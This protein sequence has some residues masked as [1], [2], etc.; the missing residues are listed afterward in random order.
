MDTT[1]LIQDLERKLDFYEYPSPDGP[2]L[3]MPLHGYIAE[4]LAAGTVYPR[5]LN[6][7]TVLGLLEGQATWLHDEEGWQALRDPV[8]LAELEE[9]RVVTFKCGL[10][11]VVRPVPVADDMPQK[12]KQQLATVAS[13]YNIRHG[14]DGWVASHVR[15]DEGRVTDV[16]YLQACDKLSASLGGYEVSFEDEDL[17][18]VGTLLWEQLRASRETPEVAFEEW[19]LK[20]VLA[21][22]RSYVFHLKFRSSEAREDFLAGAF[23]YVM[24]DDSLQDSWEQCAAD[25]ALAANRMN[26]IVRPARRD[27]AE[28]LTGSEQEAYCPALDLSQLG[29]VIERFRRLRSARFF[30]CFQW[31]KGAGNYYDYETTHHLVA[32]I[33]KYECEDGVR[34]DSFPYTRRLLQHSTQAPHLAEIL[35]RKIH[36]SPYLCLLLSDR[37]TSH[38]GLIKVHQ[39]LNGASQRLSDRYDYDRA[40]QQLVFAQALEVYAI[41]HDEPIDAEAA[42]DT[43]LAIAEVFAWLA[44]RETAPHAEG[45]G[46]VLLQGLKQ[47]VERMEYHRPEGG[48][49]LPLFKDH[50][51]SAADFLVARHKQLNDRHDEL[52]LAQWM[53]SFWCIEALSAGFMGRGAPETATAG[54]VATLLVNDYLWL[55]QQRFTSVHVDIDDGPVF[56]SFDWS[57]LLRLCNKPLRRKLIHAFDDLVVDEPEGSEAGRRGFFGAVRTH[58]RLLLALVVDAES[59]FKKDVVEALLAL[60][61]EF[62]FANDRLGGV[63]EVLKD[64]AGHGKVQ[65]WARVC[66]ASNMFAEDDFT[67]FL[68]ILRERPTPIGGLLELFEATLS[69]ARKARILEHVITLDLEAERI[70]WIPEIFRVTMMAANAGQLSLARHLAKYGASVRRSHSSVSFEPLA[71]LIELKA[72][73]EDA[74]LND[75]QR[76][77]ELEL[78]LDAATQVGD[79]AHQYARQLIAN[80][81]LTVDVQRAFHLFDALLKERKQLT[82]ATGRLKASRI[83]GKKKKTGVDIDPWQLYG[84]WH[85]VYRAV[86]LKQVDARDFEEAL[87][88]L[89][90][91][92]RWEELDR[93]WRELPDRFQRSCE[94]A[95]IRCLH[96]QEQGRVE[97]ALQHLHEVENLHGELPDV[98]KGT[99][100]TL[101]KRLRNSNVLRLKGSPHVTD[102]YIKPDHTHARVMWHEIRALAPHDQCLVFGQARDADALEQFISS[103]IYS[104]TLELLTRKNNL[105]RPT[106]PDTQ[107]VIDQENMINDWLTSLLAHRLDYLRWT[108]KDQA[109]VGSSASRNGVGEID[110]GI[111]VGTSCI[112]IVEAFRLRSFERKKVEY[113]LD[114][115]AGYNSPGVSS[116]AI[117]IYST[118]NFL[119]LCTEYE[120]WINRIPYDGFDSQGTLTLDKER[121]HLKVYRETRPVNG[122]AVHICHYLLD[123]QLGL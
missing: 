3:I 32:G 39:R 49:A 34:R 4:L 42:R 38:I 41:A 75:K 97:D 33:V 116:I 6:R 80:C 65:L 71:E 9:Q 5:V 74:A 90:E 121:P 10:L 77:D 15:V 110:G 51:A 31:W 8:P 83:L 18:G 89:V 1:R 44:E 117:V 76:I 62:G 35:F 112:S 20:M 45:K 61:R 96:L 106:A 25:I 56:D 79:E 53:F 55:L 27:S 87:G 29:D 12:L 115:I 99:F 69:S 85:E 67:A 66:Q 123:L 52:P 84:Q 105:Y 14:I 91:C 54:H 60:I 101:E 59:G 2:D 28:V 95:S 118:G 26:A 21:Y 93:I 50:C 103:N 72:I 43:V 107:A 73:A 19:W 46:L 40:W 64:G 48:R 30:D 98:Q 111:Y 7:A 23:Q 47:A 108:V 24:A 37:A 13:L 114:K 102:L 92:K 104:V 113:H 94:L 63:F 86:G 16:G 17:V 11:E 57:G 36:L 58:L 100:E 70:V 88:L 120:Q 119:H 22:R 109:R 122:S 82:Y 81:C 68:S 78:F